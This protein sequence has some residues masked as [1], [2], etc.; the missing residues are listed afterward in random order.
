MPRK[1]RKERLPVKVY[2]LG[3]LEGSRLDFGREELWER[4]DAPLAALAARLPV[5][6]VSEAQMDRLFP[7]ERRR[8]FL[9]DWLRERL[10]RMRERDVEDEEPFAPLWDLDQVDG[11]AWG[12]WAVVV[13]A[14]LYLRRLDPR[15]KGDVPSLAAREPDLEA[16]AAFGAEEGPAILLCPE[17]ILAWA[18]R[19]GVPEE[20]ALDKVYYHELG[21][22][23]M[24][25]AGLLPDPYREPWGRVVEESLANLVAFRRFRGRE[26]LWAAALIREQPPEYRGYA[27]LSTH[28]FP[29]HQ[30]LP[31]LPFWHPFFREVWEDYLRWLRRRGFPLRYSPL[32]LL[33]T[34]QD[35]GE[36]NL[37]T[38]RETKRLGLWQNPE[39]ARAWGAFARLLLEEA[40]GA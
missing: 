33:P 8:L 36:L 11:E 22:A 27:A 6:L 30:G 35:P 37:L 17:R 9:E 34:P 7:P 38:W 29:F 10:R 32:L 21:H 23:L 39:A 16:L 3:S 12:R 5:Y 25:T 18:G 24:D 31:P 28:L 40:V 13:A 4:L 20:V 1:A 19:A 2:D 14:G 26:A 15:S